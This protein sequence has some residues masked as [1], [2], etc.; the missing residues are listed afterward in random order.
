MPRKQEI[1]QFYDFSVLFIY[2]YKEEVSKRKECGMKSSISSGHCILS[3]V[4]AGA[5]SVLLTVYPLHTVPSR[6]PE[7]VFEM[8][9]VVNCPEALV[10]SILWFFCLV[11]I[12]QKITIWGSTLDVCLFFLYF[13]CGRSKTS[14]WSILTSCYLTSYALGSSSIK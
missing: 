14:R 3:S 6:G 11:G 13:S 8:K 5:L 1:F 9:N 10:I 2:N 12:L 4:R 7:I